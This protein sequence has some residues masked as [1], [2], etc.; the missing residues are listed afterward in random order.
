MIIFS[1]ASILLGHPGFALKL[2]IFAFWILSLA[3]AQ[4]IWEVKN[5]R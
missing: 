5:E 2:M 3:T 4:Y 1:G